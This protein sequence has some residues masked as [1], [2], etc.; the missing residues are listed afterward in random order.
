MSYD[1]LDIPSIL[2]YIYYPR[3]DHTP[4]PPG[5][6]CF[7]IE[8]DRDQQVSIGCR[9][10]S[11]NRE[12]PLLVY[13]HGNGEVAADYDDIAN[14]YLARSIN[15]FVADFRG[16][17]SSSGQ[18]TI[19]SQLGDAPLIF[20]RAIELLREREYTGRAFIMGRSMGS[21]S[22]LEIVAH[23]PDGPAGL[24]LE[25]GFFCISRLLKL[26]NLPA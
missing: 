19:V 7:D 18:P 24:I 25:S 2:Q 3:S 14:L 5:C 12:W 4:P 21:L 20:K 16:Y 26:F 13:F 6:E 8:V 22:A 10:Y 9:F 11:R 1:K 15:L 17:G 23:N